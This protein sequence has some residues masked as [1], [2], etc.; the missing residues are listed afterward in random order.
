M[1]TSNFVY[2]YTCIKGNDR[3]EAEEILTRF[4]TYKETKADKEVIREFY[5]YCRSIEQ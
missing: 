2:W 4:D 3:Q 5:V 1:I